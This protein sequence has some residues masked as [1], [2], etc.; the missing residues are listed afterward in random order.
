VFYAGGG[1]L[2]LYRT[3][4]ID[5]E[6]APNIA[7][8]WGIY[9]QR[10]GYQD[11]VKEWFFLSGQWSWD[12][13]K[14]I[15]TVSIL[16]DRKRFKKDHTDDYHVVKTLHGVISEADIL[17]GHNLKGHDL[18]KLQAKF[19]E[20]RLKPVKMPQLVDTLEW[21]KKF[22][23]TSRKLGDLCKKLSLQDKLSHEPGL[24]LKAA[25]GNEEAI[26]A[27]I[28]YG[29]GDI[30]T[31]RHLYYRLRP[32][33]HNHPNINLYRGTGV[34]C[35]PRCG[36]THFKKDGCKYN[37]S[38]VKQQFACLADDCG[39]KFCGKSVKRVVMR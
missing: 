5:T 23:F 35:C 37:L 22:G 4:F 10:I 26:R 28:K 14:Q 12:D 9:E 33:A 27:I 7:A 31:L 1:S 13:S 20:H 8:T 24:F 34:E 18:K 21:A 2:N 15:N 29:K 32:Y 36:S 25:L 11:I 6:N 19:V 38:T 17:V 3:C 30:P 39:H 16:D